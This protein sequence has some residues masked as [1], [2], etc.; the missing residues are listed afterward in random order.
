MAKL[1]DCILSHGVSLLLSGCIVHSR[2]KPAEFESL[3]FGLLLPLL[4]RFRLGKQLFGRDD[5]LADGLVVPVDGAAHVQ[6]RPF[7]ACLADQDVI[8]VGTVGL[9]VRED[10]LA[11]RN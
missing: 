4:G 2:L 10:G 5:F 1:D 7:H 9:H 8:E 11:R 6:E 3:P